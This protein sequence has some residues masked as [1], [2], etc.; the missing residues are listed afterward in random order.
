MKLS[1]HFDSSEFACKGKSCCKGSYPV[2]EKLLLSLEI[3]R[4]TVSKA[5]GVDTPLNINSGF[6]CRAH[7]QSIGGAGNSYHTR[8][9]AVDIKTPE[10]MDDWYFFQIAKNLKVGDNYLF[11]GI[12]YYDGWLH[13][14][15]RES[16]QVV[17]DKRST[18]T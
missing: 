5:L 15:V 9:S 2:A 14:D 3:L 16:K 17:W 7:N 11:G 6:R 1:K 12:G 10:G 13:A 4:G 8:G 18:T